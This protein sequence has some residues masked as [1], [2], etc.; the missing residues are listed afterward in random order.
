MEYNIKQILLSYAGIINIIWIVNLIVLC[1]QLN[2]TGFLIKDSWLKINSY[3]LD[4][5]CGLFGNSGT[6][7]LAFFSIFVFVYNMCYASN[8]NKRKQS[9][10]ICYTIFTCLMMYILSTLNDNKAFLFLFPI[11]VVLYIFLKVSWGEKNYLSRV[12]KILLVAT[13]TFIISLILIQIPMINDKV[14]SVLISISKIINV[15]YTSAIGGSE[16]LAIFIYALMHGNG[17]STGVGLGAYSWTQGKVAYF[18]YFGLSSIGACTLLGGIW[19]YIL[20][21]LLH[22]EVACC[23]RSSIKISR[24]GNIGIWVLIIVA[25]IYSNIFTSLTSTIWILLSFVIVFVSM[26]NYKDLKKRGV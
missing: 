20:M 21:S 14:N 16:R 11:V 10:F 15:D 1:I 25:S 22:K 18:S 13:V 6:H 23:F 2:G 4:Q 8:C 3:Y 12:K 19:F 9:F 24:I 26:P 7:E 5:C 17:W